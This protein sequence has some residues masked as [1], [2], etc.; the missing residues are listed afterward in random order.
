M[1]IIVP[2]SE[3]KRV[4]P[5]RGR[6][7]TFDELSFPALTAMRMRVLD[8]LIETSARPDAF[9]RLLVGPSFAEEVARNA[10]LREVTARPVLEVYSGTLHDGLDAASLSPSARRRAAR[11]VVVASA[12]WGLLRPADR[13]PSYRLN[14]RAR[15]VGVD[16]L[17]PAWRTVLPDVLAE[18]AG[19]RGVILDLRSS[20]YQALGMPTGLGDGTVMLRVAGDEAG[21]GRIGTVFVKRVRGQAA[22]HLLESGANPRDP[23]ALAEVLGERWP[24]GLEPPARPGRPWSLTVFMSA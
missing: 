18:A 17:E 14:V 9:T 13:I 10:R 2:S 4:P 22:R 8:A 11:W 12:L 5:R 19:P 6:P 7:V 20:S 24:V 1:L 3:S 21:G 16:R 23:G 15:L